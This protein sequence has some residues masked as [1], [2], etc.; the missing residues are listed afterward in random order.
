MLGFNL[1][2]KM[3]E[4]FLPPNTKVEDFIIDVKPYDFLI[5]NH[6]DFKSFIDYINNVWNSDISKLD[7]INKFC[8][9]FDKM[10]LFSLD[11]NSKDFKFNDNDSIKKFKNFIPIVGDIEYIISDLVDCFYLKNN[12]NLN[13]FLPSIKANYNGNIILYFYSDKYNNLEIIYKGD[14]DEDGH[15]FISCQLIEKSNIFCNSFYICKDD[16]N[17]N[18]INYGLEQMLLKV[19][20]SNL[21]Y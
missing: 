2:K 18:N 21:K 17:Y 20:N 12:I 16:L 9:Y 14:K 15:M 10:H 3:V 13:T 7:N 11:F 19:Y 5:K 4:S 1:N 6:N 8:G